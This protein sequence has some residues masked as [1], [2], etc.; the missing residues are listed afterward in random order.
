[1][2]RIRLLAY[3]GVA[4]Y[5]LHSPFKLN[6]YT[7]TSPSNTILSFL[8]LHYLQ[9]THDAATDGILGDYVPEVNVPI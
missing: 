9:G 7:K 8:S 1:M 3:Q 2:M 5:S 6:I 4:K